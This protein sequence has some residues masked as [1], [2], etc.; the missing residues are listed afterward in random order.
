MKKSAI[1][2]SLILLL[3]F[4]FVLTPAPAQADQVIKAKRHTDAFSMMGQS[5]PAKDEEVTTWLTKDM[6]RRDEGNMMTL[7][8][9]DLNKICLIDHSK[10]TYSEMNLPLDM[11]TVLP[12]EAKQMLDQMEMSSSV[13]DTGEIKTINNW[14]C[15]KYLV[16]ISVSMM[17]MSMPIKMDFWASKDLGIDEDLYKKFYAETLSLNPM[18]QDMV[19][20]FKKIE[21]YPV[22]TEFSMSMMGA[23]QK[24]WEEVVSVE[25][26][27]A[28]AGT[29]DL[30]EGYKKTEFNPFEQQR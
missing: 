21:G 15:K 7:V 25:K 12:P 22:R 19:E 3:V 16:E 1:F 9:Y 2:V 26:M 4:A 30:P 8:R 24:Y 10:K 20:E 23:E 13:T 29:Y 11:E 14:Q 5:Q 28:P 6:M 17:G 27:S 18:F